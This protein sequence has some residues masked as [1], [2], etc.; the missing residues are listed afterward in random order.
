MKV[1]PAV[2]IIHLSVRTIPPEEGAY[3]TVSTGVRLT[4]LLR[5]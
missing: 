4:D 3:P 5:R 2:T 1:A